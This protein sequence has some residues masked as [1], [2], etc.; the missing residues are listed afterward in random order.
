MSCASKSK[1]KHRGEM[2]NILKALEGM[3]R[4]F[5]QQQ[6]LL[7]HQLQQGVA[8]QQRQQQGQRGRRLNGDGD[9]QEQSA[10]E[11]DANCGR[12]QFEKL[13]PPLFNGEPYPMIAKKWVMRVE[14]IFEALGCSKEQ[15]VVMVVFKLEGEA[16]HWWKMTK[17]GLELEQRDLTVGQYEAKFTELASYSEVVRQALAI[18]KDWEENQKQK[19]QQGGTWGN[20]PKGRREFEP[21]EGNKRAKKAELEKVPPLKM[22]GPCGKCGKNHDTKDCRRV[23]GAC[24]R[25]GKM[26]HLIKDC[27]MQAQQ[28]Q[29]KPKVH[30]RVFAITQKDA[31][32][33]QSII[34][35]Q[36]LLVDSILLDIQDFDVILGMDWLSTYRV[37]C[38]SKCVTFHIPNQFEIHFEGIREASLSLISAM[39]AYRLLRKGCHSYLAY[40]SNSKSELPELDKI[41]VVKEFPD[42]FPEDLPGLPP[43]QEIEF[44]IDLLPRTTPISK[45]P[46]RMATVELEELKRQLQELL[47]KGFIRPNVGI[48][49]TEVKGDDIPKTAFQTRYGHY[50]FLVM[51]FDKVTFLGHV[52]SR[53]GISIDPNK[54]EV[55]VKWERPTNVTEVR[56]F[57]GLAGYY[58]QFVE[59]FSRLA[60]PLPHLTQKNVNTGGFVVFSDASCKGLGCVLMQN[61]KVV[62][63]ASRQL[64]TY[65]QN[66]PTHGLELA[67]VIFALKIWRH[68]LYGE[69]FE[70]YTDHKSLKYLFSQKELNMR[71]RRWLDLLKDYDYTIQ[72]HPGKANVAADALSRK[73]A[74]FMAHLRAKEWRL[75]KEL[76]D[77]NVE[78]SLNSSGVLIANMRVEPIIKKKIF[79]AQQID[80]QILHC[81]EEAKKG[82]Q[83]EFKVNKDGIL[84]FRGRICVPNDPKQV[85]AEHQKPAG[86][87]QPLPIPEWKWE[88]ITMD[89]VS[90]LPRTSRKHDAVWVVVDKL[91]KSSHF[92]PIR[93]N[94]SLESLAQLYIREI[95]RLHGV[96]VSIVLDKDPRF[97]T[98]FWK[99]LQDALGTKLDLNTAFH[100]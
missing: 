82:L 71:Q 45:A 85:K 73:S 59:G 40:V 80:P 54:V 18:E 83:S 27:P 15:K 93:M 56:S 64:K 32:A 30:G 19:N 52:I 65:E 91:T 10:V 39:R 88:H 86:T 8:P 47:D 31:Q 38:Y 75:L 44:S 70:I 62:A 24:F 100:P 26:G 51:P 41:R 49:S 60:T 61:G 84:R 1:P 90:G 17:A 95:V 97:T 22:V 13:N 37:D 34:Q 5:Q 79:E 58:R 46:Y 3:A 92:Q 48:S 7:Q 35:D 55:V 21:K 57:L 20:M 98:Q 99:S 33:S 14:K 69:S 63:Y 81:M 43:D 67:V 9:G 74:R 42:V 12:H 76:R 36:D 11:N 6:E 4:I 72:Y 2:S 16:K 28:Q 50:E 78:L 94:K 89:F 96:P 29:E 77:L 23:S 53:E 87:L 68:Y 66:Y 25:C